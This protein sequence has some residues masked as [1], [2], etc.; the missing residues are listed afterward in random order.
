MSTNPPLS[1][2][3]RFAQLFPDPSTAAPSRAFW[4]R[5]PVVAIGVVALVVAVAIA[6]THVLSASGPDYQVATAQVRTIDAMLHGVGT[7]EPVSQATVAFPAAGTVAAVN[8]KV[9]DSVSSGQALATLSTQSLQQT[10][11]QKQA[12][13]AQAQLT[14]S[15]ALAGQS[16]SGVSGSGAS[17]SSSSSPSFQSVGTRTSDVM[18][19]AAASSGDPALAA[20]QQA[21]LTAQ[22]KV[23]A[24]LAAA[25]SALSAAQSV[26]AGAGSTS[27]PA[28]SRST[29]GA[30][31]PP[32]TTTTTPPPSTT[33]PAGGD[34]TACQAALQAVM[35]AQSAVNAAQHALA[36]ASTALDDLLGQ[37]AAESTPAPGSQSGGASSSTGSAGTSPGAS[38]SARGS[39]TGSSP[40]AADLAA[41]QSAVDAAASQVEV[42]QQAVNQATITTPIA[43][44][45]VAVNFGVGDT[46]TSASQTATVVVQGSGGY[47]SSITVG[48][49]QIPRVAVGDAATVT[50]DGSHKGL[51]AKVAAISVAPTATS[52]T[53]Y[54]VVLGLVDPNA[55][56]DNG[57]TGTTRIVTRRAT[58]A[59]AVPTSAVTTNGTSH[60]VRI[61][62]GNSPKVVSVGVGV[63]GD[64]WTQITS[65]IRAGQQVVLADRSQP[66][67][68]SATNSANGA[69]S[70]TT[71]LGRFTVPGGVTG[72]GLRGAGTGR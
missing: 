1:A 54:L 15:K 68:G 5:K 46:V 26:C 16:V 12:A 36:N 23:D 37:R 57:S 24:S 28:N 7:I 33:A 39:S 43:G 25:A 21:V 29:V 51:A 6:T 63:V 4:R 22:Q 20:A 66:L 52:P 70:S 64:T 45:V 59:V 40:T 9:G 18:L 19:T 17:G 72:G 67:P 10:L 34:V 55:K 53:T 71:P 50:P 58:K 27:T 65:G 8:V 56:L 42:A 32:P 62:S 41:Y 2:S 35:A 31:G 38:S 30:A 60:T 61:L 44:T 69:T 49:D 47:E 3:E 13:L 14:L 11:D 48:V